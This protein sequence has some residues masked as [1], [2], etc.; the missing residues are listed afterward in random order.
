MNK[1][2]IDGWEVFEFKCINCGWVSKHL[3]IN[4]ENPTEI[5][6]PVW[7]CES[8]YKYQEGDLIFTGKVENP[9]FKYENKK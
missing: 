5:I 2:I 7:K 6:C 8:I 4:A 3:Y 1:Q 9:F